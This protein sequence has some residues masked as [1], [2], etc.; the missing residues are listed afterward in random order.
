MNHMCLT[1]LQKSN[2]A[3]WQ[4]LFHPTALKFRVL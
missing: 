4:M 1:S 3:R 2:W